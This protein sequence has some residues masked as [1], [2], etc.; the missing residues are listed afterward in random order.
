MTALAPRRPRGP[1]P[2]VTA[3]QVQ[4]ARQMI[5][6]EGASISEAAR[7]LGVS[8]STL[9]RGL[10][11]AHLS[12][13]DMAAEV[14]AMKL[15]LELLRAWRDMMVMSAPAATAEPVSQ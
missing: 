1:A 7:R 10:N 9:N 11:R 12:N 4:V 15:E 5:D 6:S 2:T 14:A 3:A 13:R 8:R